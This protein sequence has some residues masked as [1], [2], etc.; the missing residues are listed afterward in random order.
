MNPTVIQSVYRAGVDPQRWPMA[1]EAICRHVDAPSAALSFTDWQN[2]N[3]SIS[4]THGFEPEAMSIYMERFAHIDPLA[5]ATFALAPRPGFIGL[6]QDAISPEDLEKTEFYQ[7]FGAR[8]G[9]I[10]GLICVVYADG[11]L[12]AV[13]GVNR[14]PGTLFGQREVDVFRELLPHLRTAM[15]IHREL[16]QERQVGRAALATLNHLSSAVFI[17][18]EG[19]EVLHAN[20]A[21]QRLRHDWVVDGKITRRI[22]AETT[23]VRDA[24]AMAAHRLAAGQ[25]RDV[26]TF[27]ERSDGRRQL[28]VVAPVQQDT[29]YTLI[30]PLV[31]VMIPGVRRPSIEALDALG[32][33]YGLTATEARLAGA[34]AAGMDLRSAALELHLSYETARTYLK[35]IFLK[36]RTR[37]QTELVRTL[38]TSLD[39]R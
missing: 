31:A 20:A 30:Q 36:T 25:P 39:A 18:D 8:Y 32:T 33:L 27:V 17:C 14:R 13:I 16:L 1:L 7:Q 12:S 6:M 15:Q 5:R 34:L 19:G 23:R 28:V 26:A 9:Y 10:G 24:V 38:L 2:P 35:N 11:P 22:T 3:Y 29:L 37:R 21:A 4:A